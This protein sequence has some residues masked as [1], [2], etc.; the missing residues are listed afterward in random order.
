[1]TRAG[2]RSFRIDDLAREANTTVRNVRAYQDRGLL[3]APRRQGRVALYEEE[4]V[5]RLRSIGAL[6]ARGY[7]LASI[8]ELLDAWRDGR[9]LGAI[10][11]P[12]ATDVPRPLAYAPPEPLPNEEGVPSE[13]PEGIDVPSTRKRSRRAT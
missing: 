10:L 9:D 7:T 3:P 13:P 4:H 11:G 8:K 5:A 1:M 2:A 6:L 12:L